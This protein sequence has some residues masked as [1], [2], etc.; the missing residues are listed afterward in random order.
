MLKSN[1]CAAF[2]AAVAAALIVQG[3]ATPS[4]DQLVANPRCADFDFQVY[5]TADSAAVPPA[6]QRVIAD[7]ANQAKGCPVAAVDVVGLADFRGPPEPNLTLSRQRAE[8][9]ANALGKTGFPAPGFTVQGQG[10]AGAVTEGGA[11][12]PLHRRADVYVR[13]S[14]P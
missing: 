11:I 13:F 10:Q 3:C 5:F 7:A 8:A 4:R 1:R 9:V 14:K 6:A 2:A 12:E